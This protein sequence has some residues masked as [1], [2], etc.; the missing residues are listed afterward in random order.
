MKNFITN[1]VL[2]NPALWVLTLLVGIYVLFERPKSSTLLQQ[3]QQ[4]VKL[5]NQSAK[6]AQ[7]NNDSLRLQL[8]NAQKSLVIAQEIITTSQALN[9]QLSDH[10]YSHKLSDN[11]QIDSLKNYLRYI[12][13]KQQQL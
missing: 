9:Q 1:Y 13:S 4:Q 8:L 2:K 12:I 6:Q 11:T 5:A 10:Y 7:R 3:A